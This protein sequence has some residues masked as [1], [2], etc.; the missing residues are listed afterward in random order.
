MQEG[1]T[2]S[3]NSNTNTE[4]SSLNTTQ[5][6]ESNSLTQSLNALKTFNPRSTYQVD[7][8]VDAVDS[9]ST[10]R[11]AKILAVT[12]DDAARLNFDGWASKWDEVRSIC[13]EN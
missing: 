4:P 12:K 7:T 11:V 1:N 3:T 13:H 10:W 2:S 6:E 9:Y 8:Y 5:T